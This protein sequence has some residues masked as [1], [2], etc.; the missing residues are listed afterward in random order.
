MSS[1]FNLTPVPIQYLDATWNDVSPLLR[2]AA[3]RS[4]GRWSIEAIRDEVY[5]GLQQLW[6]AYNHEERIVNAF[7][8]SVG[9][10]PNRKVLSYMFMGGEELMEH[11]DII[12]KAVCEFA[13]LSGCD[14]I[15]IIGRI[16]FKKPGAK[17]GFNHIGSWFTKD[18]GGS[19]NE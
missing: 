4:D 1:D 19:L 15:E 12:D 11:L 9:N 2:K 8:T 5:K 10:Y 14:A 18:L 13:K 6:I 16:G 17:V 3:L 7:T